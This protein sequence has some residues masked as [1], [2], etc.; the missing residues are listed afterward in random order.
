MRFKQNYFWSCFEP[1]FLTSGKS[2]KCCKLYDVVHTTT[3]VNFL[4]DLESSNEL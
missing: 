1:S 2:L 4:I 3:S